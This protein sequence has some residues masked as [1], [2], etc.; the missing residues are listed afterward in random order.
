MQNDLQNK[1]ADDF[2]YGQIYV[3]AQ[4]KLKVFKQN[5]RF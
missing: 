1:G 3:F 4:I 2:T 5:T